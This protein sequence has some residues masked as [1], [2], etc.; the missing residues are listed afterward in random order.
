MDAGGG[1]K[2]PPPPPDKCEAVTFSHTQLNLLSLSVSL[3]H[4]SASRTVF[5]AAPTGQQ[6]ALNI[7]FFVVWLSAAEHVNA[8]YASVD[9][10]ARQKKECLE[11]IRG[12]CL[13][14]HGCV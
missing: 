9:V 6:F 13:K 2:M 8:V 7:F 14:R 11:G 5:L 1:L 12:V 3:P 4:L 10:R